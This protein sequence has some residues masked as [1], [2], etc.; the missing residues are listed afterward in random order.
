MVVRTWVAFNGVV[1]DSKQM[2]RPRQTSY[3]SDGRQR[4]FRQERRRTVPLKVSFAKPF[5]EIGYNV[6]PRGGVKI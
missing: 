6:P 1:V 5:K 4:H 2:Y 3:S